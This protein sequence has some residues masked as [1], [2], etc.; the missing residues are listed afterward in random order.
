MPLACAGGARL[1]SPG[2]SNEK[3]MSGKSRDRALRALRL[4]LGGD[5]GHGIGWIPGNWAQL[6]RRYVIRRR[7]Q[8]IENLGPRGR[9]PCPFCKGTVWF[10]FHC[11]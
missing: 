8:R 11:Q 2:S 1:N 7:G 5:V 10:A 4:N 3:F 6:R 9:A